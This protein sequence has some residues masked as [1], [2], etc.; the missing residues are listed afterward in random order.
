MCFLESKNYVRG[1]KKHNEHDFTIWIC[2]D[3]TNSYHWTITFHNC[4]LPSRLNCNI[5]LYKTHTVNFHQT[6]YSSIVKIKNVLGN[7]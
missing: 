6:N 1:V 7:F 4:C 2:S 3:K 5:L